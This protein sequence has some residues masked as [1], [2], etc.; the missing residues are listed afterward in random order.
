MDPVQFEGQTVVLQPPAGSPPGECGGLAIRRIFPETSVG[1]ALQSYWRPTP[2]ELAELNAGA[3][4][5]LTV[6]G[7]GHPPVW[8]D[9]E[10]AEEKP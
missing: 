4:V 9:V 8:L 10:R 7:T 5:R 2:E 1:C 6:H 3:H